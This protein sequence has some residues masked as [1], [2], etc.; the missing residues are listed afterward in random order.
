MYSPLMQTYLAYLVS[1][2]ARTWLEE[3]PLL[4]VAKRNINDPLAV[5]HIF[6]RELLRSH[7]IEPDRINCMANYAVISQA[8]NAEIG[9]K[10]PKV[11]YDALKGKT[12]DFADLQ[13]F[14]ILA[15]DRDWISAYDAFLTARAGVLAAR[16]NTFLKLH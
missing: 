16:L 12:K 5:H 10:D 13:L 6:P 14:Y 9:D 1:E 8:D 3:T 15:D 2:G 11:V 4:E 7:R